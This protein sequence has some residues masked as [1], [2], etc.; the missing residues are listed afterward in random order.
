[1][2]VLL[3]AKITEAARSPL[4]LRDIR[5]CPKPGR[6]QLLVRVRAAGAEPG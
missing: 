6:G 1:M 5:P 3:D 2:Q 4:E